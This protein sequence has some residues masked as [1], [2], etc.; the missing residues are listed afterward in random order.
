MTDTVDVFLSRATTWARTFPEATLTMPA[1]ELAVDDKARIH[2]EPSTCKL[3]RA[4]MIQ[5]ARLAL[6]VPAAN[7]PDLFQSTGRPECHP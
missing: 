7:T 2:H 3:V 1:P 5:T 6:R 4:R